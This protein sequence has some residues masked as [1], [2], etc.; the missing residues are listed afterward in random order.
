MPG[1]LDLSCT[2]T[3]TVELGKVA[4]GQGFLQPKE[5]LHKKKLPM[6]LQSEP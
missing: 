6:K 1:N 5:K 2:Q 4:V 3:H